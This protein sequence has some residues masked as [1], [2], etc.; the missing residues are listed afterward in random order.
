M[1]PLWVGEANGFSVSSHPVDVLLGIIVLPGWL[2]VTALIAFFHLP[3]LKAMRYPYMNEP[4]CSVEVTWT[5]PFHP[6]RISP[7][8]HDV[9]SCL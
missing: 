2:L 7:S 4:N 1:L 3:L 8:H 6:R 5:A 9:R